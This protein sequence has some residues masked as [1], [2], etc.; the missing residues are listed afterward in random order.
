MLFCNKCKRKDM[1]NNEITARLLYN[2]YLVFISLDGQI[3]KSQIFSFV[4]LYFHTVCFTETVKYIENVLERILQGIKLTN[5]SSYVTISEQIMEEILSRN[6]T[7]D[8]DE[9]NAEKM[10]AVTC[11]C[12]KYKKWLYILGKYNLQTTILLKIFTES[13]IL[14]HCI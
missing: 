4:A 8:N 14:I 12:K 3:W 13:F 1:L 11:K 6:F 5:I 9:C 10:A 7:T 2:S